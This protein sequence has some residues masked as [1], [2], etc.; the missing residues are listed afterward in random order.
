MTVSTSFIETPPAWTRGAPPESTVAVT[1]QCALA[2]NFDD[3]PFPA[4]CSHED[5]RDIEERVIRALEQLDMLQ[6]GRYYALK[7]LSPV[8]AQFLAERRFITWELLC[9]NGPRGVYVSGDQSLSLMVNGADH[10]CIRV[11]KG[12]LQLEEAWAAVSLFEETLSEALDFAFQ[13]RLGYLTAD[14]GHV[15][16]GLVASVLLHLPALAAGNRIG[17]QASQASGQRLMLSG[18][19]AGGVK[20]GGRHARNPMAVDAESRLDQALYSGMRGGLPCAVN[21]TV[22]DLFLLG[23]ESTLG[24]TEEEL[25]FRVRHMATEA[26]RDERAAR[27]NLLRENSRC[28]EDRAGRARG[29]ASG[30]RLLDFDEA[31]RLLSD[32]RLGA[33]TDLLETGT[34]EQLNQLLLAAQGGHLQLARGGA[35]DTLA[36]SMDRA[37][38]FRH[39]FANH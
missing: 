24:E 31:V 26:V 4:R 39:T 16:T 21:E 3:L 7:D 15:G 6:A 22:G 35:C 34:V 17:E 20:D 10:L 36:L 11:I 12:G 28:I 23:N 2:R 9:A 33:D 30:A 14:L 32:L 38:L 19:K 13:S 25:V 27:Q 8:E 29:V 1:S 18:V 37:D 5:K